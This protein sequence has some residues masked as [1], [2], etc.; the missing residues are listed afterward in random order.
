MH[1][2][3]AKE[4]E[5]CGGTMPAVEHH[6]KLHMVCQQMLGGLQNITYM[7]FPHCYVFIFAEHFG[8]EIFTPV[9]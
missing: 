6:G 5:S 8:W 9:L 3:G 4:A 2:D 7:K 1:G